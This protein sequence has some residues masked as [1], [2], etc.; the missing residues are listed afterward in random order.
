MKEKNYHLISF[1]IE[2]IPS[3]LELPQKLQKK[4]KKKIIEVMEKEAKLFKEI[5]K[6]Y[7]D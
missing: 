5:P 3:F 4:I 2:D 7:L 1:R 6:E